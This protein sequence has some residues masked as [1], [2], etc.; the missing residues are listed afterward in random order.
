MRIGKEGTMDV[1]CAWFAKSSRK[2]LLVCGLSVL[3]GCPGSNGTSDGGTDDLAPLPDAHAPAKDLVSDGGAR[4]DMGDQKPFG[5]CSPGRWCWEHPLPQGNELRTIWAFSNKDVWAAGEAG[6]IMHYDG[7]DWSAVPAPTKMLLLDLWGS[8]PDNLWA[9]GARGTLLYWDGRSWTVVPS[10]TTKALGTIWG[11]GRAEIWAGGDAG[12][13]LHWQGTA[14]DS[15]PSGTSEVIWGI[16]GGRPDDYWATIG[17]A[18][19]TAKP[20]LHW[21]GTRWSQATA[22]PLSTSRTWAIWGTGPKDVVISAN[23]PIRWDGSQWREMPVATGIFGP[24][25]EMWASGTNDWWM[26]GNGKV[27]RSA[28]GI[29][30]EQSGPALDTAAGEQLWAVQGTTPNDVWVSSYRLHH[31]DGASWK[32]IGP[33][34][35]GSSFSAGWAAGPADAWAVGGG[36]GGGLVYRRGADQWQ[37]VFQLAEDLYGIWGASANDIWAVGLKG[38]IIRWNGRDWLPVPSSTVA[39]L[40]AVLGTAADAAY[41][42][43]DQG[44]ILR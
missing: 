34:G 28:G 40:S 32:T 3:L 20:V 14:W 18:M 5:F 9:A 38:R 22:L 31:W 33:G 15:V 25:P 6:T 4:P 24:L 11:T 37:R 43:G 12:T 7:S 10:G 30:T 27:I 21:D 26:V 35:K 17:I 16:W 36:P 44:T 19:G 41:A 29:W 42:V 1:G 8:T 23:K 2:L 39:N 13:L